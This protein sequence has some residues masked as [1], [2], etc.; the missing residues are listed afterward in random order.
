MDEGA[1]G[2]GPGGRAA[3]GAAS[4]PRAMSRVLRL[5]DLLAARRSGLTLSEA[6]DAL[7]VPKSTLLASLKA[8]VADGFL[9]AEGGAYVL[10]PGAYRLAG[11]ILASWSMPDMMRPYVRGLADETR[12]SV[13]FGIV[14]WEI[15]QVIYTDGVNSTQPVQYAMRVGLRAPLHASAAGRVLLAYGPPARVAEYMKRTPFRKL[16]E[17]TL[18]TAEE[19]EAKLGEV[20]ELGYCASFGELLKDTAAIAV[21]VFDPNDEIT[22]ALMVGAPLE[23]M[24]GNYDSLLAAIRSYGRRASGLGPGDRSHAH[25]SPM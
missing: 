10:G 23:R 21:P 24:R 14:D 3:G 11:T 5:F 6:S 9:I 8:L 18:T 16:T 2:G 20:R 19:L 4:G 1:E 22:G 7:G 25:P 15:G 12:E 17:A 13:G